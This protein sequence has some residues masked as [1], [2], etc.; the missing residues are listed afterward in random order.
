[1]YACVWA[2]TCDYEL[3]CCWMFVSSCDLMAL[4]CT[5]SLQL[6]TI[7]AVSRLSG[8]FPSDVTKTLHLQGRLNWWFWWLGLWKVWC[9][10]F[11]TISLSHRICIARLWL[12]LHMCISKDAFFEAVFYSGRGNY[13]QNL[14]LLLLFTSE[15]SNESSLYQKFPTMTRKW[16]VT[17]GTSH[18]CFHRELCQYCLIIKFCLF[19]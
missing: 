18:Y 8:R 19:P 5:W 13:D 7:L 3:G 2:W 12:W 9:L 11:E 6:W 1:M 4:L 16:V 14:S 10:V 15:V 17:L